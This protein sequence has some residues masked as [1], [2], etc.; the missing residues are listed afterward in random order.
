MSDPIFRVAA[1]A[2]D[3]PAGV[4]LVA[5]L[6]GFT[7]AGGAVA[8]IAPHL[9]ETLD[10]KRVLEYDNDELLDYRARRPAVEFDADHI[11]DYTP[12]DLVL[13]LAH[14]E[15]HQPFL[16]LTGY[17]PDFKWER[18]VASVIETV[19]RYQVR[20]VT[21]VHSIPMP[22][23]HTRPIQ[24]TV[25]GNRQDLTES[26]SVWRPHTQV[27]GT[28]MHLLEYRLQQRQHPVVG[29]ILLVPH[30]LSETEFP[31]AG[32][33]AVEA[34]STGTGLILPTD[35]LRELDREFRGKLQQQVEGNAELQRLVGALEERHDD[36]M[37]NTGLRSTL[38]DGEGKLPSADDIADELQK[39]LAA[40]R[41]EDD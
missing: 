13:H 17:E 14:D 30:Y 27:P 22:V 11:A 2:P 4:P 7:D 41:P 16:L 32:I 20:S 21:W 6:T 19:E 40:R 5:A 24:Y 37:A 34:I 9:L 26:H 39:F 3:V 28:V 1:D 23:P 33:A 36:Y 12:A 15:L 35:D 38:V 18:F 8:Q 31:A 25:S 29:F 10:A